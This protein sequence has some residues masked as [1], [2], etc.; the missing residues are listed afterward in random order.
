MQQTRP[1]HD[2]PPHMPEVARPRTRSSGPV[3]TTPLP[4]RP[5]SR[6]EGRSPHSLPGGPWSEIGVPHQRRTS[7]SENVFFTVGNPVS[8]TTPGPGSDPLQ[9]YSSPLLPIS[10]GAHP[11]SLV[12]NPVRPIRT[13]TVERAHFRGSF[14]NVHGTPATADAPQVSRPP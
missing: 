3:G 9:S 1:T 2:A 11:A 7:L 5:Q 13:T 4:M 14:V 6:R 12:I 8:T 10:E